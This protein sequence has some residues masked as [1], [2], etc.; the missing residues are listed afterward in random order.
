MNYY[1]GTAWILTGT[2]EAV[3]GDAG[4]FRRVYR[5]KADNPTHFKYQIMDRFLYDVDNRVEFGPI[6]LSKIQDDEK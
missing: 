3:E 2:A 1:I 4:W 5:L 6:G